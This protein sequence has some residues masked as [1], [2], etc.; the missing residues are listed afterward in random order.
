[1][2]IPP[3]AQ[4]GPHPG[5][6]RAEIASWARAVCARS[7]RH[8]P[9][10][11]RGVLDDL[12]ERLDLIELRHAIAL[13][14]G[15]YLN[16]MP[17]VAAI[18]LAQVLDWRWDETLGGGRLAEAGVLAWRRGR[19][20]LADDVARLL[21]QRPPRTGL[22]FGERRPD[23]PAVAVVAPGADQVD[24]LARIA[25]RI[26]SV[27]GAVLAPNAQGF[28]QPARFVREARL[29]GLT[30]VI[31]WPRFQADLETPPRPGAILVE[32]EASAAGLGLP[33]THI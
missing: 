6:W 4:T 26:A 16:G 14:Y 30:P 28:R 31:P 20:S 21:D 9:T 18:D 8:P 24:H 25:P 32:D 1:M 13:V 7:Y 29:R 17:G 33:V 23:R 5:G 22:A 3:S 12:V 11:D 15:A 10:V 2:A 27:I 19:I